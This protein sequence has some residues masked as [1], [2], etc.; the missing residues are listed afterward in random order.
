VP[1]IVVTSAEQGAGKTAVA[2]AIARHAAY[3]GQAV[4]LA[5]I[6]S[7]DVRSNAVAD[8]AWY[9]SLFFAPDS[10]GAVIAESS[11]PAESDDILI[12]ETDTVP[13]GFSGPIVSVVR[14][15]AKAPANAT[16]TVVTRARGGLAVEG[17]A[18]A[19][20]TIRVP[21]D[22][23]LNGFAIDEARRLLHADVLVEGDETD[24]TCDRIVIAPIASDAGQPYF[25]R[26]ESKAVVAR[27]DKTD[28]HLA[29]MQ[30]RPACLILSGG[31]RPSEYLFDA[32]GAQGIPVLLSR[33]DTEN[34]VIA[35][36]RVFDRTRFQGERKLERMAG[37]LEQTPL[38]EALG[39]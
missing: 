35:L 23:A 24:A 22:V 3:A 4:R 32:A 12:V 15:G 2:A 1:V 28:M 16:V 11:F 13:A 39:L 10:P 30:T 37:Y 14:E 5:R 26:F 27:F 29:A 17:E 6:T 21:E 7:A 19:G 38:F 34:T 18:G 33:T 25:K 8:A 20:L 36:E 31:R 9:S